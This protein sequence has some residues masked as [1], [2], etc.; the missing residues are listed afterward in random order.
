MRYGHDARMLCGQD[1]RL[2]GWGAEDAARAEG[3]VAQHGGILQATPV[4]HVGVCLSWTAENGQVVTVT[5]DTSG[6]ALRALRGV[7]S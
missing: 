1:V 6:D 7:V 4:G 2:V 5:G 3:F